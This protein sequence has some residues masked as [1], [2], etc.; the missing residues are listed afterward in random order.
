MMVKGCRTL[1]LVAIWCMA[2]LATRAQDT[3]TVAHDTLTVTHD[4][5]IVAPDFQMETRDGRT[6]RLQELAA[7]RADA[8]ASA[9]AAQTLLMFFDPDCSDCRQE[10]F[11]MRHSSMLRRA[12]GEGRLRVVCVNI[13]TDEA[14]WR[15]TY[16]ELPREWTVAMARSDV[17]AYY[18]LSVTPVLLLMDR[19]CRISR[20]SYQFRELL[21][22]LLP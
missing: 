7:G 19:Q 18:D 10:L 9:T 15:A 4:T 1:L 20:Q 5:L 14:L 2:V 3:L 8:R 16:G 21:V 6:L 12:V 17:H 13:G 11:Q 22:D